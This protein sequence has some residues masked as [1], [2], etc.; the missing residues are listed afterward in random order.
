MNAFAKSL[1]Q[2]VLLISLSLLLML[3]YAFARHIHY[4]HH[5]DLNHDIAS[6]IFEIS[7]LQQDSTQFAPMTTSKKGPIV[8]DMP[9]ITKAT[10]QMPDVVNWQIQYQP[11]K[12]K[13]MVAQPILQMHYLTQP[14]LRRRTIYQP[15]VQNI[16]TQPVIRPIVIRHTIINP[17]VSEQPII[18]KQY[19]DQNTIV[20]Q[21]SQTQS[22]QKPQTDPTQFRDTPPQTVKGNQQMQQ[23]PQQQAPQ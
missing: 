5:N 4:P 19:Q 18:Q 7:G 16:Q 9:S 3:N 20:Q 6:T 21:Y 15:I 11:I 1:S 8:Q 14:I 17:Q 2:S 13:T 10:Q 12:Q 23:M 22:T